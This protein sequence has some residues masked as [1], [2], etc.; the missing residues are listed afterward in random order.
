MKVLFL[1]IDGVC[2]S[3]KTWGLYGH[4]S[5]IAKNDYRLDPTVLRFIELLYKKNVKIVL[6]STWRLE[7]T[8][9]EAQKFI[10]VPVLDKTC[11]RSTPNA[12]RGDEIKIWLDNHEV[13]AYCIVDDDSDMLEEQM[14][15]FVKTNYNDGLQY[16]GMIKICEI[17]GLD[18]HGLLKDEEKEP[19]I[20]ERFN[21]P[22]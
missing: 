7:V 20:D 19:A 16:K 8:P 4:S 13:E 5:P 12:I 14:P 1:D 6:S 15:Y 17:L 10:G 18:F 11:V 9:E 3:H 21:Y 22:N 2:N